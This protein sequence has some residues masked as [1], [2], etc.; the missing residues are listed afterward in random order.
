M[1]ILLIGKRRDK[2]A[3]TLEEEMYIGRTNW[4]TYIKRVTN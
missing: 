2:E 1:Y 4:E 3:K